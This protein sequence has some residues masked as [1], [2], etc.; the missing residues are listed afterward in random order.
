MK[1]PFVHL[2]DS[3]VSRSIFV[4]AA[5]KNI[6]FIYKDFYDVLHNL[7]ADPVRDPTR[8]YGHSLEDCIK[9]SQPICVITKGRSSLLGPAVIRHQEWLYL[10][11]AEDN[12][13]GETL[14]GDLRDGGGRADEVK[15]QT[16]PRES[17]SG[18]KKRRMVDSDRVMEKTLL[19]VMNVRV[20]VLLYDRGTIRQLWWQPEVWSSLLPSGEKPCSSAERWPCY[21]IHRGPWP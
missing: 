9:C 13:G 21:C 5:W 12:G 4:E 3:A 16:K 7:T 17:A 20:P 8:L 2:S 14:H 18:G 6:C 19:K 1:L 11:G 15:T 10:S